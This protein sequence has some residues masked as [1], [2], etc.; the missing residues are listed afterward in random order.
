M[1]VWPNK[2]GSLSSITGVSANE[3]RSCPVPAGTEPAW[4]ELGGEGH[5]EQAMGQSLGT[6]AQQT[7]VYSV[8]T[9]R[10]GVNKARMGAKSHETSKGQ[11]NS[12][13]GEEECWIG[14]LTG[15][16]HCILG[17]YCREH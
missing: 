12:A 3:P 8:K 6:S 2:E 7:D 13:W 5:Q 1:P 15:K 9:H 16:R 10:E 4:P 17:L 11:E 14:G